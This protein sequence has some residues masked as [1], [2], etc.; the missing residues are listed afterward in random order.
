MPDVAFAVVSSRMI[1]AT[2]LVINYLRYVTNILS[3]LLAVSCLP[4]VIFVRKF[5]YFG[6]VVQRVIA[7]NSFLTTDQRKRSTDYARAWLCVWLL[8]PIILGCVF[9]KSFTLV[10]MSIIPLSI[11]ICDIYIYILVM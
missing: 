2:S 9:L 7:K 5:C 1:V 10:M 11:E 3:L 6:I 8:W 4:F